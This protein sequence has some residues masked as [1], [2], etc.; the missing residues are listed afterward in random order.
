M[1]LFA[2]LACS[3]RFL[4]KG[5]ASRVGKAP[6]VYSPRGHAPR[7]FFRIF[8]FLLQLT[9]V[10]SSGPM[11]DNN[12]SAPQFATAEYSNQPSAD[13]CKVCQRPI[14][15]MFYRANNAMV[16]GSCA[17]RV[18]RE[19]PQ[20]SHAV[21]VR[22][23]LFG[24]GGFAIG[25][26]LYAGFEIATGISIGYLALAVGWIVGKAMMLGSKGVGGRR[27]QITAVLLTYAAVSM[28]S[29]PVAIHYMKK[30]NSQHAVTQQQPNQQ[31]QTGQPSAQAPANQ[32]GE[33]AQESSNT[34]EDF[35]KPAMS[36]AAALGTLAMLGLASPF[37]ELQAGFSG[38]IG[39]VIL[40]VGMRFAWR[41]A[42]GRGN[43]T[44]T[45]PFEKSASASA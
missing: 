23:L 3:L 37:L 24:L 25:L 31:A 38:M 44:V 14:T 36:F 15:G 28:A 34:K 26:V 4:A 43:V 20:D 6:Q 29:I 41:M 13:T 16:C 5:E 21:F 9:P 22:A 45:G 10:L 39:L 18:K 42:A 8:L 2:R 40:F 32:A 27:Y 12:P 7:R 19:I 11:P 30:D 33:Q 17:E 1:L 35:G